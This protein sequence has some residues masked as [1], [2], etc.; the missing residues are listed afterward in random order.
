MA[1]LKVIWWKH[2]S[3]AGQHS[4]AKVHQSIEVHADGSISTRQQ[5]SGLEP[6]LIEGF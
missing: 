4:S 2:N 5:L 6:E 3:K 1:V